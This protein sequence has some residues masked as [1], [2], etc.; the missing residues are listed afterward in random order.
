MTKG[1]LAAYR[2]YPTVM[3]SSRGKMLVEI[4]VGAGNNQE[5]QGMGG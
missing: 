2:L 3:Y 5:N 1:M 4:P